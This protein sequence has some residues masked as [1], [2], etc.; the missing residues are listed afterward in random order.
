M[1]GSTCEV[2]SASFEIFDENGDL[3]TANSE[4]FKYENGVL[5]FSATSTE[6]DGKVYF[7]GLGTEFIITEDPNALV[8]EEEE[9][10]EVIGASGVPIVSAASTLSAFSP[11]PSPPALSFAAPIQSAAPPVPVLPSFGFSLGGGFGGEETNSDDDIGIDD[12]EEGESEEEDTSFSF[13]P[14]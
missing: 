4:P 14:F 11:S 7:G 13:D 5:S 8:E 6:F 9:E 10:E 1:E 3:I 2:D 12:E